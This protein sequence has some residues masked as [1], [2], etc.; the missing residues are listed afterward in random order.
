MGWPPG[1]W[2]RVQYIQTIRAAKTTNG[3]QSAMTGSMRPWAPICSAYW[4]ILWQVTTIT[5]EMKMPRPDVL[6]L[7]GTSSE[8]HTS[9]IQS[10]M[11][12]SYAVFCYK[13]KN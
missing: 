3:V 13:K 5:I 8:E 9:E 1:L 6:R 2:A 7:G 12:N 10:L 4:L 11:R